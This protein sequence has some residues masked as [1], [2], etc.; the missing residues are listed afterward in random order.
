[1]S[2]AITIS[3]TAVQ[4]ATQ[5]PVYAIADELEAM[6]YRKADLSLHMEEARRRF[7]SHPSTYLEGP[8]TWPKPGVVGVW[9]EGHEVVVRW[10]DPETG[11]KTSAHR[12]TA[13]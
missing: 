3:T 5:S 4:N 13:E 1:M 6:T 7:G 12:R 11:V 2:K 9:L 8:N 10:I